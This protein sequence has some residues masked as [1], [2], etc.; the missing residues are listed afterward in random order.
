MNIIV[1]GG[2]FHFWMKTIIS[3]VRIYWYASAFPQKRTPFVLLDTV[4]ALYTRT[5]RLQI[6]Y[7]MVNSHCLRYEIVVHQS[8][9]V[10]EIAFP[11]KHGYSAMYN[12]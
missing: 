4:I 1:A 8:V 9:D 7:C 6:H 2:I 12:E 10:E 11:F 3:L 5:C